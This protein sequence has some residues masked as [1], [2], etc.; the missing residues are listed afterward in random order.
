[1]ESVLKTVVLYFVLMLLLRGI[2]GRRTIGQMTAFDLVLLLIVGDI[3]QE[4]LVGDDA[5]LTGVVLVVGTFVMIDIVLSL[6]K[7]RFTA[8]SHWIDGVPTV[9]CRNGQLDEDA[10]R[11]AR[12]KEDDIMAAAREHQGIDRREDIKLAMLEAN[13]KISI[14]P[15]R[16]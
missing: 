3:T 4:F 12:V 10:L 5:S 6:L 8:L 13:G 11:K 2:A 7:Q 15:R 16:P 1:M 14:V 9:L